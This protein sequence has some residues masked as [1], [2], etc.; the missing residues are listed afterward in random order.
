M[1]KHS[2]KSKSREPEF[3]LASNFR[4]IIL[5]HDQE[6]LVLFREETVAGYMASPFK[7]QRMNRKW[8]WALEYNGHAHINLLPKVSTTFQNRITL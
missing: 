1:K 2:K 5:N 7:R 4:E 3:V 6:D 8:V